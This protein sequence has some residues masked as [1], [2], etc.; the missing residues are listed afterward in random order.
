MYFKEYSKILEL[1]YNK[2]YPNLLFVISTKDI[3]KVEGKFFYLNFQVDIY[4]GDRHLDSFDLGQVKIKENSMSVEFIHSFFNS[5][6]FT[7]F[8]KF[9]DNEK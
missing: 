4:K 6:N 2:D 9:L 3:D 1:A 7:I 8:E 5:P